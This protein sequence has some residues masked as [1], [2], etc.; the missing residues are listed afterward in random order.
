MRGRWHLRVTDSDRALLGVRLRKGRLRCGAGPLADLNL[1]GLDGEL[2]VAA[3][4]VTLRLPTGAAHCLS[5]R[6][7]TS[8]PLRLWAEAPTYS[9]QSTSSLPK[10]PG[11]PPPLALTLPHERLLLDRGPLYLG[12]DASNQIVMDSRFASG[13]HAELFVRDRHWWVRDLGSKNGTFVDEVRV[14]EAELTGAATLRIGDQRVGLEAPADDLSAELL[15]GDSLAMRR[16]RATLQRVAP[17]A[18]PVLLLGESGTGKELLAHALHSLSRRSG[19][20]IAV[21]CGA[22]TGTLFESELFGHAR[23]A[24]TGAADDRPGAFASAAGGTLFLDE[25]GELPLPLQPKL[26]RA[27][28]GNQV[29]ALGNDATRVLD[30]R[31][32]AATHHSLEAAVNAGAF[33]ADLYHRLSVLTITAPPLRDRGDDIDVLSDHFLSTLAAP[34]RRYTLTDDA[35]AALRRHPFT[36]NVRELKNALMRGMVLAE[37]DLICREALG[38][39]TLGAESTLD[40]TERSAMVRVLFETGGDRSMA[41]RRLGVSRSSLYRK[42]ERHGITDAEIF[43]WG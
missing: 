38:L 19:P 12:T 40:A 28:E 4:T 37:G 16:L 33:R 11:D 10:S 39:V 7:F 8:G 24:Y 32:I 13:V 27:L 17:N 35:R 34:E 30:V 25:I 6:A 42:L 15:I 5:E 43:G 23:G 41:A 18:A 36:G 26:L 20:F 9:R 29:R 3:D 31:V 22:L 2:V 21:N 14:M 1:P